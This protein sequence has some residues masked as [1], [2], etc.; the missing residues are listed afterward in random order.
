MARPRKN[1]AVE[2]KEIIPT[3]DVGAEVVEKALVGVMEEVL[4]NIQDI[5]KTFSEDLQEDLPSGDTEVSDVVENVSDS[6]TEPPEAIVENNK[7]TLL[8]G[9]GNPVQTTQITL[10]HVNMEK[11]VSDILKIAYLGGE[12]DTTFHPRFNAVPFYCKMLLPTDKVVEY[13]DNEQVFEYQEDG[14]VVL[15]KAFDV[16]NL[17]KQLVEVGKKGYVLTPR[18]A[19]VVK[20]KFMVSVTGRFPLKS[21]L[22]F[23][24]DVRT[25]AKYTKEELSEFDLV[26]LK[27]LGERYEVSHR[28][29]APLIALILKAQEE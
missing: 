22:N 17:V 11:M 6:V 1:K 9:Q 2:N 25:L 10:R 19:V 24:V 7:Q 29:K 14:E 15:V 12:L 23:N 18:K 13:N 26:T 20:G 5:S 8:N 16:V 27:S 3:V 4:E 21:S 28:G